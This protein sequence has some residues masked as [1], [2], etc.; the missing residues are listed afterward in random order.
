[1]R[2]SDFEEIVKLMLKVDIFSDDIADVWDFWKK[3]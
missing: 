3:P 1:M 2:L